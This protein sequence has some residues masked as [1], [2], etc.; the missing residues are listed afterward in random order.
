LASGQPRRTFSNK[1]LPTAEKGSL[2]DSLL[3]GSSG[4]SPSVSLALSPDGH[5]LALAGG[6]G[7]VRLQDILTGKELAVFKGHKGAVNAVAFAP[8]GKTLASASA[9]MTALIWDITKIDG[10]A[11]P[12]KAP[13]P[14][15]LKAQW[16]MLADKDAAKAFAALADFAAAPKD[17]AAFL[18]EKIKPE[19][20][21]DGKRVEALIRQM[22]KGQ[23]QLRDQATRE[24]LNLGEPILPALDNALATNPPLETKRRLD[25]LRSKLTDMVLEGERLRVDRALEVLERIGTPEARAVLQALADGA[26]GALVTTRARA[27][28]NR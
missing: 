3:F 12:A 16:Q 9:D 24:L 22:G 8:D 21:L 13:Q 11:P 7:A 5:W 27:A 2:G 17:A 18:K 19:Q 6:D 23:F 14:G 20:P 10:P 1:A 26:P 28:L 4:I 25:D 15:N